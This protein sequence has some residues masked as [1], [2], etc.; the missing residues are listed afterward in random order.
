MKRTSRLRA[1]SQARQAIAGERR[2]LVEELI[3]E[4]PVCE[5]RLVCDGHPS[6]DVHEILSRG[7]G[8]SILDRR[9]CLCL[10]RPCHSWITEHPEIAQRTGFAMP[11]WAPGSYDDP[12]GMCEDARATGTLIDW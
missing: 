9:N 1:R 10:C 3:S 2:R 11:S 8:G 4:H 12:W 6:V 7:R 5:A